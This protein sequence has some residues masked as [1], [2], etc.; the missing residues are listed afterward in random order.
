VGSFCRYD[1]GDR[2][3]LCFYAVPTDPG[4]CRII[5]TVAMP[6]MKLKGPPA[7]IVKFLKS[8][9]GLWLDH[10][11]RNDVL[12][13]DNC[14]L[15][16]Q[17]PPPPRISGQRNCFLTLQVAPSPPSVPVHVHGENYFLALQGTPPPPPKPPNLSSSVAPIWE[18]STV[19]WPYK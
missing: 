11:N 16:L 19:V 18:A 12:D 13:G 5:F 6:S 7:L 3:Q 4:R 10:F 2:R 17:V 8:R 15:A 9:W 1:H 14:F